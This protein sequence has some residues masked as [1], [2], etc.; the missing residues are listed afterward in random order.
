M[1]DLN[2]LTSGEIF[3][4]NNPMVLA[5]NRHQATIIGALFSYDAAGYAAGTVVA[6]NSVSGLYCAYNDS[7][8][9]S[10]VDT[11]VGVLFNDIDV[12]D[13]ATANSVVLQNVIVGGKVFYAKLTGI[14][15]NAITD[16]KARN[17]TD[18]TG[19]VIMM[20]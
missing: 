17:V 2:A 9:A 11:A 8:A 3:R 15:A 13:F 14:D 10:G 20:F 1:T 18:A 16:L 5:M 19:D 4:K 12:T 6:R 7:I